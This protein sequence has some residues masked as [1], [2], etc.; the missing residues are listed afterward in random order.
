MG[1]FESLFWRKDEKAT[2]VYKGRSGL[3]EFYGGL[4][5]VINRSQLVTSGGCHHD[6]LGRS[7]LRFRIKSIENRRTNENREEEGDN[8]HAYTKKEGLQAANCV[9]SCAIHW[10]LD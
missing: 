6:L 4:L 7:C 10:I 3:N 5:S 9:K 8:V 2:S 1:G